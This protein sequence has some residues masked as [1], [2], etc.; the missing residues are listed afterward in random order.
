MAMKCKDYGFSNDKLYLLYFLA[1]V[2]ISLGTKILAYR[3][4][5]KIVVYTVLWR[6]Y[7]P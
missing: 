5:V 6:G 2:Y 7:I 3:T 4:E 1:L